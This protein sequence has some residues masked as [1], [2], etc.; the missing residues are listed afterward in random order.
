MKI[1]EEHDAVLKFLFERI[2]QA[3]NVSE[4]ISNYLNLIEALHKYYDL[5]SSLESL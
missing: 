5:K 4:A 2:E 1:K 3:E